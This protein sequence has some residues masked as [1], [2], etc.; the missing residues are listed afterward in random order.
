MECDIEDII[1][2][3]WLRDNVLLGIDLTLEDGTAYPDAIFLQTIRQAVSAVERNLDV[4]IRHYAVE[5]ER[6]DYFRPNSEGWFPLAL[7]KTPLRQM[8]GLSAQLGSFPM[9]EYPLSWLTVTSA[10]HGKVNIIP[11][12]ESLGIRSHAISG[13]LGLHTMYHAHEFVPGYFAFDYDAGF[14]FWQGDVT[15][16]EGDTSAEVTFPFTLPDR[17]DASVSLTTANGITKFRASRVSTSKIVFSSDVA[18]AGGD[19]VAAVTIS[20]APY[21]LLMLIGIYAG[22]LPMTVA[23]DLVLGAGIAGQ[24]TSMDGLS[25]SIQ[26]TS[27]AMY[28]AYSARI[29]ALLAQGKSLEA[30]LKGKYATRQMAVI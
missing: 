28:S 10:N 15:I 18:P 27:S 5:N 30:A 23:G 9:V 1:T 7:D 3:Q 22:L 24:T 19:A 25:Q 20:S 12:A 2:P 14:Y 16:P 13:G 11:S 26:S 4:Q 21:D 17:P 8:V 29:N 6:H